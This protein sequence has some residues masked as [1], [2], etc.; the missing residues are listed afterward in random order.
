LSITSPRLCFLDFSARH[1][2]GYLEVAELEGVFHA[3]RR[4]LQELRFGPTHV[5]HDRVLEVF[6]RGLDQFAVSG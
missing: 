4:S 5:A 2:L 3:L 1:L 6:D